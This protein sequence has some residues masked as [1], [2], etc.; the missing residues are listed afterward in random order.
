MITQRIDVCESYG[1]PF[2]RSFY[3]SLSIQKKSKGSLQSKLKVASVWPFNACSKVAT[4]WVCH[5]HCTGTVNRKLI[6]SQWEEPRP[7]KYSSAGYT[8]FALSSPRLIWVRV[9]FGYQLVW[10]RVNWKA[11]GAWQHS[12]NYDNFYVPRPGRAGFLGLTVNLT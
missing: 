9:D 7:N 4:G 8:W 11:T 10:V 1:F 3:A 5:D 12:D 2:I 6:K